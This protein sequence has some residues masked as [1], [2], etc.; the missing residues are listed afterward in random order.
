MIV[1]RGAGIIY[2]QRQPAGRFSPINVNVKWSGNL[3]FAN[4][5]NNWL[6]NVYETKYI[7]QLRNIVR[8]KE[9]EQD[10]LILVTLMFDISSIRNTSTK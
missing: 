2:K 4:V 3:F 8:K 9:G 7:E 1:Q 10:D 6:W 5:K